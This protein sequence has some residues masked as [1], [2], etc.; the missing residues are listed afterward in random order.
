MQR[1][2]RQNAWMLTTL[3]YRHLLTVYPAVAA[4]L[5]AADCQLCW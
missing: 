2:W 5:R 4:P 3:N 1:C